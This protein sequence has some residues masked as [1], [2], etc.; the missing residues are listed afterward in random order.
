MPQPLF[1]FSPLE[2]EWF[3][4]CETEV[5]I[6]MIWDAVYYCGTYYTFESGGYGF[7]W[8]VGTSI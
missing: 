4:D 6:V 8:N 1:T 7:V 2:Y 5:A 3:L